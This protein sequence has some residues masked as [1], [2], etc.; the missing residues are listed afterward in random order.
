MISVSLVKNILRWKELIEEI[1][2]VG[3]GVSFGLLVL[4]IGDFL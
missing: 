4:G 3:L 2:G 1:R